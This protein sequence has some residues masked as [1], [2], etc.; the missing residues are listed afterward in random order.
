MFNYCTTPAE[1]L[2]WQFIIYKNCQLCVRTNNH[3]FLLLTFE[4]PE[5]IPH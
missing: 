1:R 5:R 2:Q 4:N 3:G